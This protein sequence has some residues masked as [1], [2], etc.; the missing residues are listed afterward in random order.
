MSKTLRA[1]RM[2]RLA[3]PTTPL[4]EGVTPNTL[5]LEVENVDVTVEQ[6]GIIALLTDVVQLNSTASCTECGN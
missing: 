4:V 5:A 2:K 3:L 6:W 1:I